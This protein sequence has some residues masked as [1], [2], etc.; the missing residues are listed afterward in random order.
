LRSPGSG[1][2]CAAPADASGE[3]FR[4]ELARTRTLRAFSGAEH[5]ATVRQVPDAS[6]RLNDA[7]AMF[8]AVERAAGVPMAHV[9]ISV[10][11]G[12]HDAQQLAHLREVLARL[13]P[14]QRRRVARDPLSIALPRWVDVPGFDPE[15]NEVRLPAPPGD[16]SMRAI[17]DWAAEWSRIPMDPAKPPWRSVTFEG[18]TW[19]GQPGLEVTV[20]QTHHAIIDGQGAT[21]LGQRLLQFAPDG[22]LPEMP[23]EVPADTSTAWDRWRE[24][25]ILE[26]EKAVAGAR[27]AG[28]WLRWAGG[29][30]REGWERGREWAQAVQRM[31]ARAGG[32][33]RSPIL[34]RRSSASRFDIVDLDFAAFRA[35]CKAVG[36][37]VNDGFLGAL[38]VALH[39]YHLEHGLRLPSLRTAMAINTRTDAHAE[40]GN[41]VIGVMMELPLHD[42]VGVAIKECR[43]V[44]RDH[45]DDVDLIRLT[46]ALRRVGNRLP[47]SVVARGSK[48]ALSGLDLQISNVQG[49]PVRHWVAGVESLDGVSFPTAGP[50]LSMT[51][52]SARGEA[53]LGITTCPDSVRDPERLVELLAEGFE[54]VGSLA[55]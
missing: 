3:R 24:G 10:S 17:L 38:S 19:R 43:E 45:R 41:Q 20:S 26:G 11:A 50:G 30:P 13:L 23:P 22:P 25:W 33:P 42:D 21:R 40:G 7:D 18:T 6:R 39:Q 15:E 35:G 29:H 5:V 9:S 34:A 52:V 48:A 14:A 46:E 12:G 8:F 36:V 1:R 47:R 49:I 55:G 2:G 37:S 54:Q 32:E 44:S 53:V 4:S 31:R 51:F 28:R 16:G 27:R